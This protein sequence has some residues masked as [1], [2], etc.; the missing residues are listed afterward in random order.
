MKTKFIAVLVAILLLTVLF[1]IFFH[2]HEVTVCSD[3]ARKVN[4]RIDE[5]VKLK[6]YPDIQLNVLEIDKG[7]NRCLLE[8][9]NVSEGKIINSNWLKVGDRISFSPTGEVAPRG[10]LVREIGENLVLVMVYWG[11]VGS[12]YRW[13]WR[14]GE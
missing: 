13:G 10:P 11:E 6:A 14:F 4:L 1:F 3:Y 9:N 12:E 8:V 2:P 5:P 7:N